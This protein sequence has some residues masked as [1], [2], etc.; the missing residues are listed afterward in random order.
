M[1]KRVGIRGCPSPCTLSLAT[2]CPGSGLP[3]GFGQEA[4]QDRG[5]GVT[6]VADPNFTRHR[7]AALKCLGPMF[8][9]QFKMREPAASEIEYAVDAPIRPFAAGFAD[10]GAIGEAWR[11]VWPAQS[12]AGRLRR[13]QSPDNGREERHRLLQPVMNTGI[14]EFDDFQ[15]RHSA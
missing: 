3:A 7:G 6:T 11:A 13:Q 12:G 9:G 1:F 2:T 4:F 5:A 14:A 10:A 15:Q 8:A